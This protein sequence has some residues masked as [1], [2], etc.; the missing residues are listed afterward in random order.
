MRKLTKS[1]IFVVVLLFIPAKGKRIPTKEQMMVMLTGKICLKM[2][3]YL[4]ICLKPN[5]V[6]VSRMDLTIMKLS[7][8]LQETAQD[9]L[10]VERA[11]MISTRQTTHGDRCAQVLVRVTYPARLRFQT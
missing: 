3:F 10:N 9:C 11:G 1:E 4:K 2:S 7:M 8:N 5:D 6:K